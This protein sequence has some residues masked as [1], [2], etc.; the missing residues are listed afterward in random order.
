MGYWLYNEG[1]IK[2][3]TWWAEENV[4]DFGENISDNWIYSGAWVQWSPYLTSLLSSDT[5]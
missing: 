4:K 5:T 1:V 3:K 2:D